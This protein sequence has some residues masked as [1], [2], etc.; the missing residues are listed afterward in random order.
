MSNYDDASLIMFPS[1]YKEDKI[2]SLKPTDGSGDLTFTRASTATRVNS[3]G[4]IETA[5]VLGTEL[6]SSTLI[7]SNYDTFNEASSSGFHAIYSTSGTQRAATLDEISFVS[8]K[9][10]QVNIDVS[11]VSGSVPFLRAREAIAT[12]PTIFSGQLVDGSNVVTFTSTN[13]LTGVLE[14]SSTTASEYRVSNVSVKEVITSNVPRIDYKGG[15]CGKLLLEPQRTNLVTYSEQMDNAAWNKTNATVTANA[16]TSPDG[17]TNA[18]KLVE[19]VASG[20]HA[21]AR[22]GGMASAGTYSLSVYAKAS[23]RTR[24]AIGN[25]SAGHYAI[26]DLSL[27]TIVQAS[28]G[29]VTNGAISLIGANGFYRV[30]CTI[31]VASA[32]SAVLNLV[33]TGTTISYTGNGTSGIFVWGAQLEAGAYPTSYIPTLASSVTRLADA[34]FKTGISSLIGSVAGTMYVEVAALA[35]DLSERRFALS[36][37]TTGNVARVG[38]TSTSNRIIA[39][40]YNGANQC[41]MTYDGAD[42]TQTNKIAFTWSVNDFALFVNGVKRAS[43]VSGTTFSANT[44]TELQF[45]GGAGAGNN[46]Y[47]EFQQILLFKTR[48]T[49]TELATLTTL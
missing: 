31:T 22:V 12:S 45:N 27:G 38:F 34:A 5:S 43:D 4:L 7:N 49:D 14:F 19:T 39:V 10:Y 8:G 13:T 48:L 18:D 36:D 16:T 1:G 32:A 44:L 30:S 28:Q 6:I 25:S 24:I 26:F 46:M 40:L 17:T 9:T 42:I 41:V 11:V 23:E 29:T 47:G 21:I 2:Y 37:G 3:D 15:G 33:S 20:E 35:N